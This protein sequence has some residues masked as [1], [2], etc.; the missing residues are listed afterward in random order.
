MTTTMCVTLQAVLNAFAIH[1]LRS[2]ICTNL[3]TGPHYLSLIQH[4][5][6]TSHQL[7]NIPQH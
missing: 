7:H 1:C 2:L 5:F 3:S 6:L 4:S